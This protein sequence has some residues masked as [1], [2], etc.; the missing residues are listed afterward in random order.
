MFELESLRFEGHLT[1]AGRYPK[2]CSNGRRDVTLGLG[3]FG[4]RVF[5]I[6]SRISN[7]ECDLMIFALG[8]W[9]K[10]VIPPRYYF[11]LGIN[12]LEKILSQKAGAYRHVLLV[13]RDRMS[14]EA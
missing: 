7:A 11:S 3:R 8:N 4:V 5:M 10:P 13:G 1:F 14:T 12:F 9:G 6:E 2:R